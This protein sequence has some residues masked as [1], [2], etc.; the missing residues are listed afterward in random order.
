MNVILLS[1]YV[2][3]FIHVKR[4]YFLYFLFF[5]TA[6]FKPLCH[7]G[8]KSREDSDC[9]W[10]NVFF[11]YFFLYL[12]GREKMLKST[13]ILS[14]FNTIYHKNMH[15]NM[16]MNE[17]ERMWIKWWNNLNKNLYH[18]SFEHTYIKR[19]A[20]YSGRYC[21]FTIVLQISRCTT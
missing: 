1:G 6:L 17:W 4:S 20:K 8:C 15:V 14:T 2:S 10:A 13:C 5:W 12:R 7:T 3:P 21:C 16:N 9:F 11:M 19:C 18:K